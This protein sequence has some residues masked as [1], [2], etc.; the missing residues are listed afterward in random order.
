MAIIKDEDSK[1]NFELTNKHF[2]AWLV[3][4]D[5]MTIE[6]ATKENKHKGNGQFFVRMNSQDVDELESFTK[7]LF[8]SLN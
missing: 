7:K 8:N 6:E 1:F 4:R 5:E 3:Q 2:I